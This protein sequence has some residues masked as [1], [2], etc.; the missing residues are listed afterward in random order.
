MRYVQLLI[1]NP[2]IVRSYETLVG[3]LYLL[4]R[5]QPLKTILV[6]SAEPAEGKT[7]V[8]LH[9][10]L[11]MMFSGK[12]VLILDADLRRPNL[13]QIFGLQNAPG[14]TDVLGGRLGVEGVIQTAKM[15]D[16]SPD[17]AYTLS[18]IT[19]GRVSINNFLSLLG[20]VKLRDAMED[21]RN[22]YDLVVLDTSSV[23]SASD[24]LLIAPLVDGIILVLNTGVITERNAKCA[25]E[26]LEEAGGR[27]LGCVMNSF[28]E[29]LHG[30][31]LHPYSSPSSSTES[32]S[33]Q[34]VAGRAE[35]SLTTAQRPITVTPG[36]LPAIPEQP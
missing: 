35:E 30:P 19:S 18:V 15:T 4:S 17:S 32:G 21:L 33:G 12:K 9:L 34:N 20:P 13:H 10:A 36:I 26:R 27:M 23:L 29:R 22:V 6:T 1:S 25:K 28:S 2:D 31:G 24:P 16:S 8:T 7:T 5:T 3:N 14:F 11:A